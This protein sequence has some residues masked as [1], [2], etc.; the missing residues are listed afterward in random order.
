ML[1]Y[2]PQKN[3]KMRTLK[4]IFSLIVFFTIANIEQVVAQ[5]ISKNDRKEIKNKEQA[6]KA[7]EEMLM[8]GVDGLE[9]IKLRL[10]KLKKSKK[11]TKEEL[12]RKTKIVNSVESRLSNL[13]NEIKKMKED[14]K[15]YKKS[16]NIKVVEKT[17]EKKGKT[18][19]STPDVKIGA[20][21]LAKREERL[22]IAR[23]KLEKDKKEREQAYLKEQERLRIEQ[24]KLIKL[25]NE[26][27]AEK[28]K[29]AQAEEAEKIKV[30]NEKKR[31][32]NAL[33]DEISVDKEMLTSGKEGLERIKAK[34]EKAK[35]EGGLTQE[36]I[37]RKEM[38]ISN[39]KKRL[40]SIEKSI[41]E[42]K[43]AILKVQN[44]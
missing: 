32:I 21:D 17:K 8:S 28:E 29:I 38:V 24:E 10:E 13:D 14:L 44:N 6:I 27:K 41:Q 42:K 31:H 16:L 3:I 9:K 11:V 37:N 5:E 33:K 25:D 18:F 39:I 35:K 22:R 4:I 7:K 26:I 34:L 1:N 19:K 40:L 36:D 12:K 20:D 43:D 2:N 23:E 15:S 30:L